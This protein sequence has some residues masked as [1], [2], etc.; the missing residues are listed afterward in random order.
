MAYVT[1][2]MR[3]RARDEQTAHLKGPCGHL[4][5]QFHEYP[6]TWTL[7]G[8]ELVEVEDARYRPFLFRCDV[9]ETE[10]DRATD[11]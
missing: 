9:C 10:I 7:E 8:G 1:R 3:Q 2:A 5:S 11:E 6:S 4:R